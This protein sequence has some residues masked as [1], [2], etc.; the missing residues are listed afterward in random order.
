MHELSFFPLVRDKNGKSGAGDVS[1][2]SEPSGKATGEG[3]LPGPEVAVKGEPGIV[4]K[5]RSESF[6]EGFSLFRAM[7]ED[8]LLEVI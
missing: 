7:R 1:L 5:E 8:A 4:G 6:S 2:D 3:C